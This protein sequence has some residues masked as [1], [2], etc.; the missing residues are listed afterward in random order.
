MVSFTSMMSLNKH[1]KTQTL[2]S[3]KYI[4]LSKYK[5]K[6]IFFLNQIKFELKIKF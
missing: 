1:L 3:S 6:V 5:D 4:F 2:F